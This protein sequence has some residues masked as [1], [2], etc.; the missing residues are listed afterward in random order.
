MNKEALKENYFSNRL[1]EAEFV[2]L[3]QLLETDATFREEFYD[4]LEIQQALAGEKHRP[5]KERLQKLD[6]KPAR[7]NH[8]YLYAAALVALISIGSLFYNPTPDYEDVY[9]T[10]FEA[11][12]NVVS[13]TNRSDAPQEGV[14]K[15]AFELY[16]A[17]QYKEAAAAFQELY[18]QRPEDYVHFY[19]GLSLMAGGET[20]AGID[21]LETY[22]WQEENSDFTTVADWYIG[23][24][25]VK[26]GNSTDAR[27]Y[28]QKVADGENSLSK[29]AQEVLEALD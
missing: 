23:L 26:L 2:Q 19:Y 25:Y 4:A 27:F 18:R 11:Y 28:L 16:E 24:G 20:E 5:L 14:A 8:W 15:E 6:Q 1:S 22:P 21:A 12:P 3:E 7:K 10:H 13:L 9:A 17:N 29:R